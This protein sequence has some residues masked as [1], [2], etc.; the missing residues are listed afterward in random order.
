MGAPHPPRLGH[1]GLG[2]NDMSY[3]ATLFDCQISAA[4]KAEATDLFCAAIEQ[5]LGGAANVASAY[6]AYAAAFA[7]HGELPL[8]TEATAAERA[9]VER[10]EDAERVG[11]QAAFAGWRNLGGAHFEIE[12]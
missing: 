8:P 1:Q 10:W 3:T 5:A 12:C 11:S 4:A 2:K 9:A 7:E 6:K